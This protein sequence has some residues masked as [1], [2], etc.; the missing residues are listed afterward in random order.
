MTRHHRLTLLLAAGCLMLSP[1]LAAAAGP[2]QLSGGSVSPGSG[3]TQT[4][5]T[6]SVVYRSERDFAAT[7]VVALVAGRTVALA[8]VS[9]TATAGTYRGSATLPVGTWPVTFQAQATQGPD[10]TLAGPT[11]VVSAPATPRPVPATPTPTP[12]PAAATPAPTPPPAAT[13]TV[14][15][16]APHTA[17]PSPSAASVA[18]GSARPGESASAADPSGGGASASSVAATTAPSPSEIASSSAGLGV[19]GVVSTSPT[20]PEP[21]DPLPWL[22]IVGLA[23]A[24]GVP[25]VAWRW[26]A[27]SADQALPVPTEA[28]DRQPISMAARAR[29]RQ[30]A[31]SSHSED[32]ILAAMGLGAP[33]PGEAPL[34]APLTRSISSGPGERPEPAQRRRRAG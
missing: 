18:S 11:V 10:A 31:A 12:K 9:G 34:G 30:V 26:R 29:Q 7:G 2:N 16:T 32:P 13:A 20:D 23:I 14:G 4:A 21:G 22:L 17:A 1:G 6:F 33:P 27:G 24:G 8:L 15:V 5:F 25:L 28:A 19:P 3:T